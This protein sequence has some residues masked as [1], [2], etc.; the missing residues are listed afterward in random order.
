MKPICKSECRWLYWRNEG[1]RLKRDKFKKYAKNRMNRSRRRFFKSGIQN[2]KNNANHTMSDEFIDGEL[3]DLEII[4][5]YMNNVG[6]FYASRKKDF[7]DKGKDP[8]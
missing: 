8:W 3:D 2:I 7:L 4:S 1:P 6:E 5:T